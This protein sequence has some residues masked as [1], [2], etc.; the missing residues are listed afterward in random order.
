MDDG[1]EPPWFETLFGDAWL[2]LAREIPAE[3]TRAEVEFIASVLELRPGAHMLDLACGH[4]RHALALARLGFH[5]TG[6][7][8]S[9]DAIEAAREAGE[10]AGIDID[11]R[12][13]DMREIRF[14]AEFDAVI[15]MFTAFGY[16][17]DEADDEAVLHAVGRALRPGG[18]FLIDVINLLALMRE[19]A[20]TGWQEAPD[21]TL[22]LDD[23][24]YD[25]RS[26]RN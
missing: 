25:A 12:H 24:R 13:T 2:E 8:L 5:V 15:N 19:Y 21:G 11:L 14:D 6:V 7:D 10:G 4:G 1:N 18:V 3:R 26:G 22:W 17:A 9:G 23:R 16:F 20:S